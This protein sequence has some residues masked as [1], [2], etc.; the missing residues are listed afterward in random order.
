MGG[1]RSSGCGCL[2]DWEQ[3]GSRCFK[4]F[5]TPMNWINAEKYCMYFGAHLASIHNPGEHD[6]LLGMASETN[7]QRAW[8]G[9]SDAVETFTWLWSDGS[10]FD[11]TNWAPYEPD[12]WH[13]QEKC[14]EITLTGWNDLNCE[15]SLP[16]ICGTRPDGPL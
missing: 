14:N 5:T 7:Q 13:G 16:F 2:P 1:M 10:M 4:L 15:Y 3:Y 11:Y 9:N 6:L 8:I 12:N